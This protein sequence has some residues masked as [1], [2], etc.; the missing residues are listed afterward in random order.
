MKHESSVTQESLD[1]LLAWLDTDRDRAAGKY[2]Q[3]RQRLIK[4][5]T[6][7]GRHDAEELTDETIDRVTIKVPEVARDYV[8]DPIR[9]FHGVARKVLLEALRRKPP[10]PPDEQPTPEEAEEAEEAER[11]YACLERCMEGVMSASGKLV[12]EY[13]QDDRRAKIDHRKEMAARLGIAQN[14]LR[15]R[16][17]RIK[18]TLEKC[19][20]ACLAEGQPA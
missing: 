17:H 2:E 10:Q 1:S 12:L 18:A 13:Y 20:L 8:G 14:A 15:I 5:F 4:F 9:Y 11:V 3:I 7:R 19:V 16:V 6:C